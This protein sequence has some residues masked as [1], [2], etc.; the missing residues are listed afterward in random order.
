MKLSF[1]ARAVWS[2]LIATG[3][4]AA[5]SDHARVFLLDHQTAASPS[6]TRHETVDPITA[7]LILAERLSLSQFYD[8]PDDNEDRLLSLNRFGG[9]SKQQML[10]NGQQERDTRVL[11]VV[12]GVENTE[13]KVS[14]KSG[15]AS[16]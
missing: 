12:D 14:E 9:A 13:G 4:A 11:I 15:R 1:T 6:D 7:R 5:A 8:V 16:R 10:M 2:L 3:T